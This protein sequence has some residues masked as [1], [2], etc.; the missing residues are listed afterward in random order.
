MAGFEYLSNDNFNPDC[1]LVQTGLVQILQGGVPSRFRGTAALGCEGKR[2][3][4]TTIV[5]D[6]KKYQDARVHRI[7]NVQPTEMLGI[8]VNRNLGIRK[9][10]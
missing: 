9:A 5:S 10:R 2:V 7:I 6:T 8:Y 1:L 4:T 3:V